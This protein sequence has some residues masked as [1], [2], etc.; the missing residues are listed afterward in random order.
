MQSR[1]SSFTESC[2]NTASGFVISFAAGFVV[3]PLFGFP[4]SVST[5]LMLT[6]IYTA[7]SVVHSYVWRRIFNHRQKPKFD[8]VAHLDRQRAFSVTTF[9]PAQ[10]LEGVVGHIE[11]ELAEIRSKP[12]D[13]EEWIDV[14]ILALDGAWRFTGATSEE[15]VAA[16]VAKQTKNESRQWPDWRTVDP[17]KAIEHVRPI[18]GVDYAAPGGGCIGVVEID[19]FEGEFQSRPRYVRLYEGSAY[20]PLERLKHR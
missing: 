8:L 14:I 2:L 5:N 17:N 4:T 6:A 18:V 15:I 13:L 1:M 7:I 12:S 19:G 11:K 16:L 3:F 10:G 20:E 9:G